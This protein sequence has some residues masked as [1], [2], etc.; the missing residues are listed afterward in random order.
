MA[1]PTKRRKIR[2]AEAKRDALLERGSKTK[3]ELAM[4]R[5]QLKTLKK[6]SA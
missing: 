5:A 1:D 6:R 3:Q 2:A 4:V